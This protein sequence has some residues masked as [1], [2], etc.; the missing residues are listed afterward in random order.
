MTW[1]WARFPSRPRR[2]AP[3]RAEGLGASRDSG[4]R[5]GS[6][7]QADPGLLLPRPDT[8]ELGR[9]RPTLPAVTQG[10]ADLP[11]PGLGVILRKEHLSSASGVV[12]ARGRDCVVGVRRGPDHPR[13]SR[14]PLDS[15]ARGRRPAPM[16]REGTCACRSPLFAA[17]PD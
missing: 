12:A 3:R 10:P 9:P 7:L 4:G 5:R 14:Y 6:R 16:G 17:E 15:E 13:G 2:P 8:W 11:H 1:V